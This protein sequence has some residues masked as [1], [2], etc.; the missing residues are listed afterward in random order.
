MTPLITDDIG[1]KCYDHEPSMSQSERPQ[2]SCATQ[3]NSWP[4]HM[5]SSRSKEK[6]IE[7]MKFLFNFI[8]IPIKKISY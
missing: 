8:I 5:I 4:K 1:Q 2:E 3:P 6:M 7:I